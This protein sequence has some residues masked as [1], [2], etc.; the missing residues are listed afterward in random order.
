MYHGVNDCISCVVCTV[1]AIEHWYSG[2][3]SFANN[4]TL[5]QSMS[6]VVKMFIYCNAETKHFM[7]VM[8]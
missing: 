4:W 6:Q 1:I 8:E 2:L 7:L 3:F 5:S